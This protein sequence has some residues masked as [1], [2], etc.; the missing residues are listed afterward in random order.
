MPSV[1]GAPTR[2][3]PR[4]GRWLPHALIATAFVVVLPALALWAIVPRGDAALLALS[5][6]CGMLLSVLAANVGGALWKRTPGSRDVV[7]ADLMLWGWLRRLRAERRLARAETL[8]V[9]D[10]DGLSV[11]ALTELSVLLETRDS[12]TYGHS[13]R[14]ARH[15]ERI[16]TAMGLSTA[17]V[18]KVRTAAALH[19][20]GKLHTPR[21]ILNKPG[22]LTDEEFAQIRL[23]P[24]DGAAMSLGLDDPIITAV[25]RHHHERLD[26]AGYPAGLAGENIPLGSRIIAVADT[27]DAM[28]SNRAYRRA[29]SHKRA[30]DVLRQEA[31]SQ[32]DARAVAAFLDY[33]RGRRGVV[34]S[35]FA[36][37]APQRLFAWLGGISPGLGTGATGAAALAIGLGVPQPAVSPAAAAPRVAAVRAQSPAHALAPVSSVPYAARA[38]G[39]DPSPQ[40]SPSRPVPGKRSH[41]QAQRR[42][43]R[44]THRAKAPTSHGNT[45]AAMPQPVTPQPV[46]PQKV[47]PQKVKPQKVKP[48]KVKPPKPPAPATKPD[49][50]RPPKPAPPS[51]KP[52]KVKPPKRAP[53]NGRAGEAQAGGGGGRPTSGGAADQ[54]VLGRTKM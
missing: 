39:P 12:Y 38:G 21:T 52:D 23:H 54:K 26:G 25:I 34:W 32:L 10:A 13:Q 24:V 48:Q 41:P 1:R 50:V 49:K 35:A 14:V 15:A 36:A 8:M 3:A 11:E 17:E 27:F 47:K 53:T 51:A 40:R 18:A 44:Q 22:R 28:T 30:L 20:V 16:A 6:P 5:V 19:D 2:I 37:A 33:Y 31:G 9:G 29:T 43:D 45:P 4:T 7:F 42:T 46:K